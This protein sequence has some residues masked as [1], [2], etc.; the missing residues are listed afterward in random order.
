MTD[1]TQSYFYEIFF[2]VV[3]LMIIVAYC[4]RPITR[5]LQQQEQ[6]DLETVSIIISPPDE[7]L[8]PLAL[9][10]HTHSHLH[11]VVLADVLEDSH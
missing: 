3:F 6:Q 5:N 8:I 2:A 4:T 9:A 7:R 11:E 1:I 10:V